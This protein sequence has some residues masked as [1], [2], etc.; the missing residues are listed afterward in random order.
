[1]EHVFTTE[2]RQRW[3]DI[4]MGCLHRFMDICE[5]YGLTYYCVGGTV[6]GAVRHRGFIPWDD[7][8]DVAMPRPDY[9]KL[10]QIAKDHDFGG[11]ELATPSMEGYPY[12]FSKFCDAN[13]SLV[14]LEKVPC[15]YGVYIDV[16]PIDGTAPTKREAEQIMRRFKRINNKINAVLSH[17]TLKEYLSLVLQPKE[18]GRMAMQT[19]A[20][21]LGRENV[22]RWLIGALERIAAKYDYN[23]S[24]Y[25]VNY[26]GAWAEKEIHPKEWIFP[27][28]TKHFEDVDVYIPGDYDRYLRQMYG[29]YMQ[30]PPEEKRVS[31]HDHYF[32][33]LYKRVN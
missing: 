28:T 21:I 25:I 17:L 23:Q 31:H 18:W 26:G 6:I 24:T 16:F 11:Y 33:D 27:L 14:E 12:F 9:D 22:R 5:Q 4:L 2:E 19:A 20:F 13:T 10:L 32:V 30:L 7:D 3:N 29:D 15:L 1:M 8:I